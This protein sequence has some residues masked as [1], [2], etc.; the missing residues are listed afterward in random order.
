MLSPPSGC[1]ASHGTTGSVHRRCPRFHPA[2]FHPSPLRAALA[3]LG[4]PFVRVAASPRVPLRGRAVK[5]KGFAAVLIR[6]FAVLS[7]A[8][9]A[10]SARPLD[11]PPAALRRCPYG[12]GGRPAALPPC[13]TGNHGHSLNPPRK[14]Q[15][16]TYTATAPLCE[17]KTIEGFR[18]FLNEKKEQYR[19]TLRNM[20]NPEDYENYGEYEKAFEMYKKAHEQWMYAFKAETLLMAYLGELIIQE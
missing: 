4:V 6:S 2:G 11:C 20:K 19:E 18:S 17:A 3:V 7:P 5:G 15:T 14:E 13:P 10:A 1:R 9:A 16:M 12:H 8:K